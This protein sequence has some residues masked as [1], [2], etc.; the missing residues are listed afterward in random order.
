[1][2]HYYLFCMKKLL[3]VLFISAFACN[4]YAQ[5]YQ[6][7]NTVNRLVESEEEADLQEKERFNLHMQATYILQ[8]KPAFTSPYESKNSLTGKEADENSLTA[9]LFFGARLWKGAD[10]YINP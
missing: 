5:D 6:F 3:P 7:P 10:I 4:T 8:Y 9:T 2:L 1:M